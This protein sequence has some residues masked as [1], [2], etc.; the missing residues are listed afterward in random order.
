MKQPARPALKHFL[1]AT[2]L[3]S[4]FCLAPTQLLA[5]ELTSPDNTKANQRDRNSAEATADQEEN[6]SDRD[7]TRRVRQA[8]Q[9]DKSLSTY[10]HNVKIITQKG[11]M[12]MKGPVRSEEKTIANKG[13][14]WLVRAT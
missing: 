2:M 9:N 14:R 4:S 3:A 13:S 6:T 10:A 12:T 5:Q 8:L 1:L 7:T 11:I